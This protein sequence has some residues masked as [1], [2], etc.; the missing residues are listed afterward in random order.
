V[1]TPRP[2]VL[3]DAP[4]FGGSIGASLVLASETFQHTGSFK[5]RAAYR[6][7]TTRPECEF[8]AASSG[9][10][11]A[12]LAAACAW[13]GRT[14]TVVVPTG[15]ADV[16]VAA[17]ERWGARIVRVDCFRSS[18][19]ECIS[20]VKEELRDAYIADAGEDQAVL[21]GNATLGA[22]LSEHA[23]DDIVVPI[24]CGGL[25]AGIALALARC[26]SKARLIGVEPALANR[27]QR[28]LDAGSVVDLGEESR[29]IA[30]G[31]RV[32]AMGRAPF[33]ILRTGLHAVLAVNE[34][35]IADA[36]RHLYQHAHLKA[37]PTGALALAGVLT[38]PEAFA[39]RNV[40]CVVSGAN[41]GAGL[42]SS[43]IGATW[44]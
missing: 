24:G 31:A 14:C 17:I 42:Y 27:M 11:G 22:E 6:V 18:R 21:E 16:K 3:I 33:A 1:S 38:T 30:D 39:S 8:I 43:L 40:C 34:R 32:R 44:T 36:V 7:V 2:V 25:A 13:H 37:E 20:R 10:F 4:S 35:Q 23:F 26:Q 28:S 15:A 9:N 41:I 12:A 5:Y 19:A 29:T